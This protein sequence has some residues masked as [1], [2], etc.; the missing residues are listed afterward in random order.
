[1]QDR[2][3]LTQDAFSLIEILI[4]ISIFSI[5]MLAVVSLQISSMNV[6]A[7]SRRLTDAT[8][9]ASERMERLLALPYN[10]NN[11]LDT[12]GD[13]DAG[14]GYI[15]EDDNNADFQETN[16]IYNIFWNIAENQFIN[17]TKTIR[18]IA[19][20]DN[21]GEQRQVVLQQVKNR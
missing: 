21:R 18:V 6:N 2:P 11:L 15:G 4:A 13:G 7:S 10:H 1:M 14:L 16:G 3:I 12:D 19:V 5:G 20:Y 8:A 17:D 9:M